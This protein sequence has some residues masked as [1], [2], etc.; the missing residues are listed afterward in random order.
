MELSENARASLP[1]IIN[2]SAKTIMFLPL[3]HVFARFI[4]VLA[5]AG[6]VKV[7]HTPPDIKNLLADLQSFQPTFILAVPPRVSRRSTTRR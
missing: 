1:E 4:S 6:G 2:E 3:A 7:A 5:V